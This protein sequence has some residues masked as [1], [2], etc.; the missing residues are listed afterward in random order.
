MLHDKI[1]LDTIKV[2]RKELQKLHSDAHLHLSK[3]KSQK[4]LCKCFL[5][6]LQEFIKCIAT[7]LHSTIYCLMFARFVLIQTEQKPRSAYEVLRSFARYLNRTKTM[8]PWS[9]MFRGTLIEWTKKLLFPSLY[10][11][12]FSAQELTSIDYTPHRRIV[13]QALNP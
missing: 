5:T 9:Y 3:T 8:K 12:S 2:S 13:W 4:C 10:S 11:V 6:I 1:R 7:K